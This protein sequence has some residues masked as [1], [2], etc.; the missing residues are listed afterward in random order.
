[1]NDGSNEMPGIWRAVTTWKAGLGALICVVLTLLVTLPFLTEPVYESEA[2]VYVPLV[3]PNQ[4]LSQQGVGFAGEHEIDSYIQILKSS[5]MADSLL[6]HLGISLGTP[7]HKNQ[8]YKKLG[9][10]IKVEKTRYGS[11][12]IK[13]RDAS[14]EKATDLANYIITL[15]ESIKQ[16][17][18]LPNREEALLYSKSLYDQKSE[19]IQTLEKTIESLEQKGS[20]LK[21]TFEYEKALSAY[22]LEFQEYILRKNQYERA[23]KD[24]E[25]PLPKVYV[26]SPA[27][28]AEKVWPQRLILCV[29]VV[30]VY[31]ILLIVIEIIKRDFA[32]KT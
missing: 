5:L 24:F 29:L 8:G 18:L 14:P 23:K 21:R 28:T 10:R 9:S 11:V 20:A 12:S 7:E 3:I 16:N 30:L 15:G 25:A 19:E 26:V 13:V 1:M 6:D 31:G 27:M 2:I 22:K 4:Q 32:R 17:L